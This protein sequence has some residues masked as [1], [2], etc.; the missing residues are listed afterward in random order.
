MKLYILEG[1]GWWPENRGKVLKYLILP[2]MGLIELVEY[3]EEP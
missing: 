3:N 1:E 2:P